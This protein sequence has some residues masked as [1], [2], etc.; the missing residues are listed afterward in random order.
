[1]AHRMVPAVLVI[2]GLAAASPATSLGTDVYLPLAGPGSESAP[3]ST[4]VWVFNPNPAPARVTFSW[5]PTQPNPTPASFTDTVAGGEIKRYDNAVRFMFHETTVGALRVVASER[6]L[7]ASRL[8]AEGAEG[9]V[10]ASPGHYL[11]AL[12]ASLAVGSGERSQLVAVQP[13]DPTSRQTRL[14]VGVVEVTGHPCTVALHLYDEAGVE[15]STPRTWQVGEREYRHESLGTL[16]GSQPASCRVE[17]EVRDGSGRV[18]LFGAALGEG[19]EDAGVPELILAEPQ[20]EAAS[21][22]Q[23]AGMAAGSSAAAPS[24]GSGPTFPPQVTAGTPP[25]GTL[26]APRIG[27]GAANA[28]LQ[29]SAALKSFAKVDTTAGV[30]GENTATGTTGVLGGSD[31]GVSGTQQSAGTSGKLAT[32]AYG[33]WGDSPAGAGVYGQSSDGYGVFGTSNV[34]PGVHGQHS[35]GNSGRLGTSGEGVY[36][37]AACENGN[38]VYGRAD[39]GTSAQGVS[40]ISQQ[41]VGVFGKNMSTNNFGILGTTSSGVY[42]TSTNGW[43]VRAASTNSFGVY[44]TSM[45]DTGVYGWSQDSYGVCGDS[46]NGTGVFGST[47]GGGEGVWGKSLKTNGTGVKG[48]ANTGSE[49][50]GVLGSSSE[51]RGVYGWSNSGRGVFGESGSDDGVYGKGNDHGVWGEHPS[52]GNK[53]YLGGASRAVYGAALSQDGNGVRGIA[54]NGSN[55]CGVYGASSSGWAGYFSGNVNVTGTLSKGAGSLRIDH[56][57]DPEH[58]YLYHSFVESPDM[59]NIYNGN[60]VTDENGFAE[61]ILPEWF[62]ALN[63]DFRYQLTVIDDSDRFVLAKVVQEIHDNRFTIRTNYGHVKVSWQVTGIR[64]D[65][66]AEAHRIPVEEVKPPEEQGTYL[67]PKEWGQPEEKGKD[68]REIAKLRGEEV[69]LTPPVPAPKR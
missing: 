58:K 26:P 22:Q 30:L 62:E 13:L 46:E 59:M 9:S 65:P 17:A 66:F 6:V 54:N 7:V 56:P 5:L 23:G 63:K 43:G 3:W 69:A 21:S 68:Y 8:A 31:F 49:A 41:G 11:A 14:H 18:L 10:G 42:G 24:P 64:K 60:V 36:G 19:S 20:L 38:G 1:M 32:P 39:S 12:S 16:F 4:T 40:G 35:K 61:I 47:S 53:G 15:V 48:E 50:T 2:L 55:A 51:G 44:G 57:L 52:S 45:R 67:H 27:N 29:T 37:Y 33:V 34:G 28:L 25:R